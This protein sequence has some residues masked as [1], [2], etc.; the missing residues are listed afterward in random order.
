MVV[1]WAQGGAAAPARGGLSPRTGRVLE[2]LRESAA[3]EGTHGALSRSSAAALGAVA[4]R[5]GWLRV[6]VLAQRRADSRDFAYRGGMG[7]GGAE[8]PDPELLP[9]A[10]SPSVRGAVSPL[11]GLPAASQPQGAER[12]GGG[13][14]GDRGGGRWWV[15][16][17]PA[18]M[19]GAASG[20]GGP[21]ASPAARGGQRGPSPDVVG[22]LVLFADE[23]APTATLT[24]VAMGGVIPIL[25]EGEGAAVSLQQGRGDVTDQ[26]S[27]SA[28]ACV[29]FPPSLPTAAPSRAAVS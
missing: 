23:R 26:F 3:R 9:A 11:T 22:W 19:L 10:G 5:A 7:L 27:T 24:A 8:A 20:R 16:L 15:V 28:S 21:A 6:V 1:P 14:G 29:S 12:G 25:A 18:Q 13:G 17:V 4:R 2:A